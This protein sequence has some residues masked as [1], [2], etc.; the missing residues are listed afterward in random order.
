ML[1]MPLDRFT[2]PRRAG[3]R[4]GVGG[5]NSMD[6]AQNGPATPAEDFLQDKWYLFDDAWQLSASASVVKKKERVRLQWIQL[7]AQIVLYNPYQGK[8]PAEF[9]PTG[10]TSMTLG[11]QI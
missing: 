5:K 6:G 1:C 10:F 4:Q 3:S 2:K 11:S 9:A 7:M 8:R